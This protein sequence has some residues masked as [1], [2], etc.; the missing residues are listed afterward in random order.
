M[1]LAQK[2]MDRLW[3]LASALHA[4]DPDLRRAALLGNTHRAGA[5]AGGSVSKSVFGISTSSAAL[6]TTEQGGQNQNQSQSQNQLALLGNK[7]RRRGSVLLEEEFDAAG[8]G[9]GGASKSASV[10]M[11]ANVT[12]S[13]GRQVF[14]FKPWI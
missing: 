14:P 11:E 2:I 8:G 1:A 12:V 9:G 13:E 6:H 7:A 3:E 4:C 10:G 5:G